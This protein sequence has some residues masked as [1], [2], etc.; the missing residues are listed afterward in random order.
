MKYTE[1][2]FKTWGY[3]TAIEKFR[4]QIVTE[5]E[6]WIIDN[7]DSGVKDVEENAKKIEPGFDMMTDGQQ[8]ELRKEVAT[9]IST[10]G[11]S[12]GDGK[13]KKFL[14]IKDTIADITL[15]QVRQCGS[16]VIGRR[17][18]EMTHE[19]IK[20]V[21]CLLV[22]C[23][24]HYCCILLFSP[25]TLVFSPFSALVFS[26]PSCRL[27]RPLLI[28]SPFLLS[29]K[30]SFSLF[31]VPACSYFPSSSR[32][33]PLPFCPT[34][35]ILLSASSVSPIL[36]F[37]SVDSSLYFLLSC[38][39]PFLPAFPLHVRLLSLLYSPSPLPLLSL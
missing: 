20:N 7:F 22:A 3:E 23:P 18:A 24:V 15:Q 19:K 12:H 10:L 30:P 27:S 4:S 14:L 17:I 29:P 28:L 39:P 13:W 6:S 36:F 38:S 33:S 11:E 1:G 25:S 16:A 2:G 5:R 26:F 21:S 8:D 32:F 37:P 34:T 35:F 9:V 31:A